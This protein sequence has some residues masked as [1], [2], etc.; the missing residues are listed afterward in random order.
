VDVFF[1]FML[2]AV[3]LKLRFCAMRREHS[4]EKKLKLNVMRIYKKNA[5]NAPLV[6]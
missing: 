6:R 5:R 4:I 2:I 1:L 3:A